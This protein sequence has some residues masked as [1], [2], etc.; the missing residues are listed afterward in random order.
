MAKAPWFKFYAADFLS[1]PDVMGMTAEQIG[2]YGLM[3]LMSWTNTPQ[4]YITTDEQVLSTCCHCADA[5]YFNRQARSVLKK[6]QTTEDGQ[7]YFHPK[8]VEQAEH[9]GQLAEKKS[10]AG[11][12]GADARRQ[13]KPNTCSTPVKQV[14]TDSDSDSDITTTPLPPQAGE[15][16]KRRTKTQILSPYPPEVS[17]LVNEILPGWPKTQP[18][19]N[20]PIRLDVPMTAERIDGLLKEPGVTAEILKQAARGYLSE[21]KNY[22]RAPQFF[23]G[24]SSGEKT[25]PWIAYARMSVHQEAGRGL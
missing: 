17:A 2:W 24:P 12:I 10:K 15:R 25:P 4:G 18:K 13:V 8:M 11:K 7:F 14:L 16:R 9:M 23:F 5:L 19:D 3:L 21:K 22:Y 6:F 20:A 1:D